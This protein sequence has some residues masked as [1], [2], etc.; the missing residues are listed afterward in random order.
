M[1]AVT[2]MCPKLFTYDIARTMQY[3]STCKVYQ[4]NSWM[5]MNVNEQ[6]KHIHEFTFLKYDTIK[7]EVTVRFN[8][9]MWK[10]RNQNG[11]YVSGND[12]EPLYI[13]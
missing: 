10:L 9:F 8:N 4:G 6:R 12:K 5:N 3:P 13:I 1:E 2:H 7:N 11:I